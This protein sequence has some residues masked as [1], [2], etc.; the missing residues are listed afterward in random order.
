MAVC[1]VGVRQKNTGSETRSWLRVQTQWLTVR[2]D[3]ILSRRGDCQL[4]GSEIYSLPCYEGPGDL[5]FYTRHEIAGL[6]YR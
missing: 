2:G 3:T 5:Y 4:V 1:P 6:G